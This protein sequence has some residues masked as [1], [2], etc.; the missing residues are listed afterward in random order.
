MDL[1]SIMIDCFKIVSN[2]FCNIFNLISINSIELMEDLLNSN[3]LKVL[4]LV[5]IGMSSL[6]IIY[7][8][9]CK[10]EQKVH[11]QVFSMIM[12]CCLVVLLRFSFKSINLFILNS[13]ILNKSDGILFTSNFVIYECLLKVAFS[14]LLVTVSAYYIVQ[15]FVLC[16]LVLCLPFSILFMKNELVTPTYLDDVFNFICRNI[17]IPICLLIALPILN[18]HPLV[19]IA[20]SFCLIYF[21]QTITTKS[22]N[23]IL[24][25]IK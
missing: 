24:N 6:L 1:K 12:A 20:G 5:L 16:M 15:L 25:K 18:I 11:K 7:M 9:F 14:L 2:E 17:L 8:R 3:M 13:D 21:G 19:L 10:G 23:I 4:L 22:V